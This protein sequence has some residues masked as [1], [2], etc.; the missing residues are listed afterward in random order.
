MEV[1]T[2]EPPVQDRA[3]VVYSDQTHKEA[4]HIAADLKKHLIVDMDVMGRSFGAQLKYANSIGARWAVIIG[5]DEAA[6]GKV[7]LKDMDSG[8]QVLLDKN[9]LQNH[10]ATYIL[11]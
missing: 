1:C 9:E 11:K 2:I 10:I 7:S 8:K 5:E 6:Q 3:V 4:I